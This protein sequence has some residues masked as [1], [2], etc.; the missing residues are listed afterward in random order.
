MC[1]GEAGLCFANKSRIACWPTGFTSSPSW[2]SCPYGQACVEPRFPCA[3]AQPDSELKTRVSGAACDPNKSFLGFC[4]LP[5]LVSDMHSQLSGFH[6]RD[7]AWQDV[8]RRLPFC[9][10]SLMQLRVIFAKGEGGRTDMNSDLRLSSALLPQL[11]LPKA[12]IFLAS[13]TQQR[14]TH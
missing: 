10:L 4:D 9:D 14:N 3:P 11:C 7:A 13:G 12:W 6:L 8:Q 1:S 2:L 5:S